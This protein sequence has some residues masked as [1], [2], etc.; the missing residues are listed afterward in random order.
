MPYLSFISDE[1][2][3]QEVATILSTATAA[4]EKANTEFES[5]V[6][7]PFSIAF[8]M[9]GFNIKE[10]STWEVGEKSRQSQKTLCNAFGN[11]HQN[12][13]G[14]V[15]GWVNLGIGKS[16]DLACEDRKI[17]AEIK[18]KYSTVTGGKLSDLYVHL[19]GLVMP[20]VSKYKDYTSYYVETIPRPKKSKPQNY[21]VPFTPSDKAKETRKPSNELIRQIDGQSFYALVT[22]VP[23]AL[24]QLY[25][26]IPI[27][28]GA[29]S[30]Y[31]FPVEELA[32]MKAYFKKA[33]I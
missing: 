26:A 9:A 33:F 19:E 2:L 13:L 4:L 27:V 24:E 6:I 32:I 28:I 23:D 14:H 1:N 29:I 15:P 12:I 20:I 21:D 3:V 5:N 8:E 7:D 22:G 18:N 31:S 10:V 30:P 25:D 17:I 16:V 11:F